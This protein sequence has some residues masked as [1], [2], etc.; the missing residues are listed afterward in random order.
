LEVLPTFG[1]KSDHSINKL[2]TLN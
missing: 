1:L 2:K